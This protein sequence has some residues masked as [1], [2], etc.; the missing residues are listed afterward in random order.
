MIDIF[1]HICITCVLAKDTIPEYFLA[2]PFILLRTTMKK[3][4]KKTPPS[5]YGLE[6]QNTW[7]L[8]SLWLE[9]PPICNLACDYC[10]ADGGKLREPSKVISYEQYCKILEEFAAHGGKMVGIPWAGE[11][12]FGPN[13]KLT[14]DVIHKAAE[15][16]LVV[17]LFTTGE[18]ID[19]K[20]AEELYD[21]PVEIMLKCNSLDPQEQD[22][23]VS[24]PSK[25]RNIKWYGAKRNTALELF[26]SLWFNDK[27]A[28]MEKIGI[29]TRIGLVTSLMETEDGTVSNIAEVKEILRKCRNENL[30]FNSD[31]I[32]PRGRA[33]GCDLLP[34]SEVLKKS[35][36][37]LRQIDMDEF[38]YDWTP[39]WSYIWS[40]HCNRYNNH[41]YIQR[42]GD[43]HPCL[44]A[45]ELLLGNAKEDS[46]QKMRSMPEMKI[47]RNR[48]YR[49]VCAETCKNFEEHSCNSCLGRRATVGTGEELLKRG[50]VLT[51]WCF[52]RREK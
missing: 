17:T 36:D 14:M 49:G 1:Y 31:T 5:Q 20:M 19:K 13:R 41:L 7:N 28:S 47:I 46:L 23:L 10:F 40:T 8:Q 3:T 15:L 32:L 50:F 2:R 18:F 22:R 33:I 6:F 25:H 34:K 21:L 38:G 45:P 4:M 42:N 26:K 12:L 27:K 30:A 48:T 35:I 51:H 43:V 9:T 52:N 29:P 11:P 24:S 37:E 16:N 39:N 44:W